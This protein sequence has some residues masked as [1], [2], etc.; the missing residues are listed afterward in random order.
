[1]LAAVG[2]HRL[3]QVDGA[4]HVVV[5]VAKRVVYALVHVLATRKVDH[6]VKPAGCGG[7]GCTGVRGGAAGA[8]ESVHG[9]HRVGGATV[10]CCRCDCRC[11]LLAGEALLQVGDVAQV[12]L[13]EAQA[14]V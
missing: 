11:S 9:E 12:T 13:H 3:E 4:E 6:A 5:V 14:Q 8:A 1:M 2:S 7:R 10:G